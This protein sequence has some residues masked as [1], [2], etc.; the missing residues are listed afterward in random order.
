MSAENELVL[1]IDRE[2]ERERHSREGGGSGLEI[3]IY[4]NFSHQVISFV[5][6]NTLIKA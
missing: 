3:I 1:Q 6:L 2:R 4:Q 5:G